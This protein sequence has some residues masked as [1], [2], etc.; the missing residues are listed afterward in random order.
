MTVGAFTGEASCF[1]NENICF[2][3]KEAA[4]IGGIGLGFLGTVIGA[5]AGAIRR[6]E[7]WEEMP[8]E[9]IRVSLSPQRGGGVRLAA[10]FKF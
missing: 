8:L 5:T 1:N 6:A 4:I 3:K 10:S 9:R 2:E 7:R